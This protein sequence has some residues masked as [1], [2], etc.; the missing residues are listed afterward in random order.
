MIL[1]AI[2]SLGVGGAEV[3][4]VGLAC[5]MKR[6]GEDVEVLVLDGGRSHLTDKLEREGIRIRRAPR[7]GLLCPIHFFV[8]LRMLLS[9]RYDVVHT[10]LT[11]AQ[12][13]A[14]AASLFNFRGVRLYTSEH[15]TTNRR[16]GKRVLR[17]VDRFIFW[18]HKEVFCISEETRRS[19]TGWLGVADGRKYRV[20]PNCV[21]IDRFREAEP[22]DRGVL[23][24][25]G[26]DKIVMMVGRMTAAKNQ[27]TVIEAVEMLPNDYKC[28]LVGDGETFDD[29]AKAITVPGKTIMTGQRSDIAELMKMCDIY[30]HSSHWEGMPTSVLES[31]AAGKVVFGSDVDGIRSLVPEGQLFENGNAGQLKHMIESL[32][33][34]R[35]QEITDAQNDIVSKYSLS[36]I[37]DTILSA[38]KA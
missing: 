27:Q 37:T 30:V 16:R 6:K 35:E 31:M 9:G 3:Y 11:Y 4:V 12:L 23:G 26:K 29:V 32:T 17:L 18:R 14:A 21:D 10:H 15:S 33:P 34:Q 20:V 5:R 24:L 8:F 22:L 28:V 2:N 1:H 38:Y 19:L 13:W 7:V 36:A 25:D